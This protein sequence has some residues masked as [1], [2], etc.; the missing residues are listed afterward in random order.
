MTYTYALLDI[1]AATYEEI[2]RLLQEAEY[3]HAFHDDGDGHE[4]IDMHGI[5]L[6]K[7][8]DE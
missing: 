6:R 8:A 2:K 4:V 1:S 7:R 5:A 3:D